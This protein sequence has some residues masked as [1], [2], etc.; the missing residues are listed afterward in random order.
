MKQCNPKWK[1]WCIACCSSQLWL[2]PALL[3]GI[4]IAIE[5]IHTKAHLDMEDDVHQHCKNNAEYQKNIQYAGDD[6]W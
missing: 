6:E 5:A 1:Q 2:F 3:L 4:F